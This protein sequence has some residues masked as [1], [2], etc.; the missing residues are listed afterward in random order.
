MKKLYT[1]PEAELVTFYSEEEVANVDPGDESISGD[2]STADFFE[3]GF[4]DWT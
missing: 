2:M 3:L 4:S 1:K